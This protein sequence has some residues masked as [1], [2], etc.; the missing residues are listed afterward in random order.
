MNVNETTN[1][2]PL[3]TEEENPSK[4]RKLHELDTGDEENK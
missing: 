4:K 2:T 1:S 3:E